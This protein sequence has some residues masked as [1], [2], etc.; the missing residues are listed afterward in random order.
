MLNLFTYKLVGPQS[1]TAGHRIILMSSNFEHNLVLYTTVAP[2]AS[3]HWMVSRIEFCKNFEPT[4]DRPVSHFFS[5]IIGRKDDQSWTCWTFNRSEINC[6]GTAVEQSENAEKK[7]N[8]SIMRF[9]FSRE[10]VR[11]SC[12]WIVL[13][14]YSLRLLLFFT[15]LILSSKIQNKFLPM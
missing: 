6:A 8:G 10:Y 15:R 14:Y 11:S 13:V 3:S 2:C 4:L 12:L 7:K 5:H 9:S 1:R